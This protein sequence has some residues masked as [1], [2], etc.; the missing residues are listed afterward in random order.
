MLAAAAAIVGGSGAVARETT[1]DDNALQLSDGAVLRDVP[2][3]SSVDGFPSSII[4]DTELN[5]RLR[6]E[7]A[8]GSSRTD[9]SQAYAI[10]AVWES[11]SKE[12]ES[13]FGVDYRFRTS[14]PSDGATR[15]ASIVLCERSQESLSCRPLKEGVHPGAAVTAIYRLTP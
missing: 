15:G 8:G 11:A 10:D 3:S 14:G 12:E 1:A 9:Q 2:D 13:I 7:T 5:T 4:C 6:C